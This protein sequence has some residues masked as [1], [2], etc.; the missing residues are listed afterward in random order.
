MI[1]YSTILYNIYPINTRVSARFCYFFMQSKIHSGNIK[2]AYVFVLEYFFVWVLKKTEYM[3]KIRVS[4]LF[5]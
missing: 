4:R 5:G 1:Q 2:T 3:I